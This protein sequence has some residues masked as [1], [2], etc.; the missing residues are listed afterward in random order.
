MTQDRYLDR[1]RTDRQTAD[2][3]ERLFDVPGDENGP[4]ILRSGLGEEYRWWEW[5][6]R[7]SN[8]EPAD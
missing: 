2:V 6:P 4:A 7:G 5:A 3:L 8:P 1:R